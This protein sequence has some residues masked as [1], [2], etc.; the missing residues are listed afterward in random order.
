M[1]AVV[2]RVSSASVTVEDA[3][4]TGSIGTGLLVLLGVHRD[5]TPE[6]LEY[7]ARKILGLRIFHDEAEKMNRSVLDISGEILLVSQFTLLGNTRKGRRP[8][9]DAAAPP[10]RAHAMYEEMN[11]RLSR[12]VT[13]ATGRFGAKMAV[14]L[15][16]DGPV[17]ILI[18]SHDR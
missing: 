13:V 11:S 7:V 1:K 2:Q 15:T 16:N 17:T 9:F 6:D 12:E 14:Q 3:V 4:V 5:D 18:D 10:E 8:G